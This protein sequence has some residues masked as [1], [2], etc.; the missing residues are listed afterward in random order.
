MPLNIKQVITTM[1]V[2]HT[3]SRPICAYQVAKQT[4]MSPMEAGHAL[5]ALAG[6]GRILPRGVG[7]EVNA[8]A[9]EFVAA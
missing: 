5:S 2:L 1:N 8:L 6:A 9:E 7:G 3:A 4:G